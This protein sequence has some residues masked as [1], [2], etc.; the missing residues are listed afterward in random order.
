[1]Q[2]RTMNYCVLG[3]ILI[4]LQFLQLPAQVLHRSEPRQHSF[5]EGGR[6]QGAYGSL[7]S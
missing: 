2:W 7:K 5:I 1:M 6:A 4:K 3:I